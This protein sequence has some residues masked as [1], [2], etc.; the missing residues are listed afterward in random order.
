M[1]D[2]GM[3][4]TLPDGKP[5]HFFRMIRNDPE[6]KGFDDHR[7]YI[8]LHDTGNTQHGA[9]ATKHAREHGQQKAWHVIVDENTVIQQLSVRHQGRH[10]GA[11]DDQSIGV[12]VC[13][14]KDA[15]VNR[16]W[17]VAIQVVRDLRAAGIG[18]EGVQ[19]HSDVDAGADCPTKGN[20]NFRQSI[21]DACVADSEPTGLLRE[22]VGGG[23]SSLVTRIDKIVIEL[24]EI[25]KE[26]LSK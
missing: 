3:E 14:N 2:A 17:A 6:A 15:N 7:G 22:L 24:A 5:T 21:L 4:I 26:M 8:I 13:I 10:A 20:A 1:N 19:Y 25:R 9:D 16:A 12:V 11:L 18:E 23:V